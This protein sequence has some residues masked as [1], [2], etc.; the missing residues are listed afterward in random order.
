MIFKKTI[1]TLV[2]IIRLNL[3]LV[4]FKF[5]K[6]KKKIIFFYH[7]RKL[8]THNNM[9][10]IEDLLN[11]FDEKYLILYG[12]EVDH[13]FKKNYF[14]I[15]QGS[16]KWIFN[17]DLF[18]SN[19]VCEVFT[20]GAIKIYMHHDIYDTPLAAFK[21]EKELSNKLN[22]YDY[23]FVSSKISQKQFSL[24][25]QK[26]ETPSPD[27]II[28]GYAKLDFINK[29]FESST[30]IKN[31][32]I[33]APT[34]IYSFPDLEITRHL[35]KIIE[36]IFANTGFDV[37]YRPHPANRYDPKI[38]EIKNYFKN[39]SR[40]H[41]DESDNYFTTY[42]K[43]MFL[44]TDLSGT[45]YTYAFLTHNPVLFISINEDYLKKVNYDNLN[46]FKDRKKIGLVQEAG[47]NIES[48]LKELGDKKYNLKQSILEI[49]NKISYLGS[50]KERI[51]NIIIDILQ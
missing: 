23:V 4:T 46:Y 21:K 6:A 28:V 12:H 44:I 13:L 47:N 49:K 10:Y 2:S 24:L 1:K 38:I 16:L 29:N 20:K 31:Q 33:I 7:P 8:L 22:K 27:I 48:K 36:G 50:S 14:F 41:F 32:I 37:V 15:S 19:N 17:V 42:S 11:Q 18:L 25:F 43:S 5:F 26:N 30:H 9:Y 34:N 51:K 35:K 3:T 45:A 40:F 39:S